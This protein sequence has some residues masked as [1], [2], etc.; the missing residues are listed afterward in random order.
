MRITFCLWL[1]LVTHCAYAAGSSAPI[2]VNNYVIPGVFASA[3]E[4]GMT[5]PVF[6]RFSGDESS[7]RSKQKIADAILSIKDS[8]FLIKQISLSDSAN[9]TELAPEVKGLLENLK[10]KSFGDSTT[11]KLSNDVSITLDTKSFYLELTVGRAAMEA[12]TL[13]RT[14]ILDASSVDNLSNILNYTIGSYYNNNGSGRSNS[15]ITLDNT[16]ALRE[17][18]INLNGSIY[19][20]GTNDASGELYRAMYERDFQGHVLAMGMVDT[21]NLQSIA[22]MNGLNSSRIY[23]VSYGNKSNTKIEDNTLS[24]VPVTVFL[25]AAG[26]VHIY[27]ENR[28]LSIQKFSMGSYEVDTSRL[29]FGVYN[30]DVQVVVNGKV[31]SSRIAQINKTFAR[32]SSVTDGL[33]WQ[34]FGGALD[35]NK[36][37][38]RKLNNTDYADTDYGDKKTWL[39][40]VALATSKP[41]FSGTNLRTTLYG[42]D[43]NGVNESEINVIFNDLVSANQQTLLASDRS[44]QSISTLNLSIPGGY[45]SV[46]GAKNY[47]HTGK[48]LS[49]QNENAQSIGASLNLRQISTYLGYLTVSRTRDKYLANSYTNVDYSQSLFSNR[50]AEVSLRAGI[51]RYQYDDRTS[52]SDKYVNVEVSLPISTWLSAGVSSERGSLLANAAVRK[53]IDN[54]AITQV[55]ASLSK[56]IKND[57]NNESYS[58]DDYTANG[59]VSYDTKYS[60]GTVSVTRSS[61]HNSNVSFSSLGSI[62][63]TKNSVALGKGN[64]SSGIMINTKFNDNGKMTALINGVNYP[65]TGKSNFIGLP[66]YAEY[67]VELMNDKNSEDSVDIVSGRKSKVVLYPGNIGV[68]NPEVKQLVTVFGRIRKPDG[69]IYINTDI[70]NHIGKSK[71]NDVGEFAMDVDKRYPIISLETANGGVCEADLDLRNARGAVWVGDIQCNG[72][73]RMASIDS[74]RSKRFD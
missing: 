60:A 25:P 71:T 24:L 49:M 3:L 53:N 7:D 59:Y 68:I 12:A 62:A 15:Y 18:H 29:P 27:R 52:P 16:T 51:Q 61:D 42:F 38:Y 30:V 1:A 19:G 14:N 47:T 17:H 58:A 36:I 67:N 70:H 57:G 44:W 40:G 2:K 13:P 66:P 50:Y 5:I 23:G 31:V 10:D 56:R 4:Q 22:S 9:G 55:G 35:Y 74:D 43:N 69:E 6:I 21:W 54:N 41:W 33:S 46:W 45:G 48:R 64:Q 20:V 72:Q 65:I 32:K 11:I 8:A 73:E 34:F 28:L 39:S 63:W 26:E 37:Q